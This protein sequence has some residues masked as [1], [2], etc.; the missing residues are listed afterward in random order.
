MRCGLL[1]QAP[2]S[3]QTL[4]PLTCNVDSFVARTKIS[5]HL[6]SPHVHS[7]PGFRRAILFFQSLTS[8]TQQMPNNLIFCRAKPAPAHYCRHCSAKIEA[9][10]SSLFRQSTSA[11][12]ATPLFTRVVSATKDSAPTVDA[13]CCVCA[14]FFVLLPFFTQYLCSCWRRICDCV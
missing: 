13:V 1:S 6:S 3:N 12:P 4:T 9:T 14:P 8:F 11:A 10:D 5:T 2:H 7:L